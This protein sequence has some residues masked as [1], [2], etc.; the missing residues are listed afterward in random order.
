MS[1]N[2][3]QLYEEL[4]FIDKKEFIRFSDFNN[5][6]FNNISLRYQNAIKEMMPEAMFCLEDEPFILFF[7]LERNKNYEQELVK[8]YRQ[9]WNFDKAPVVVV[10]SP[11]DI[12][13]YNAF[14]F[15]KDTNRL[16]ILTNR[17]EDFQNFAYENLYTG[18]IFNNYEN[19]FKSKLRV[20][21]LLFKQ[22][23]DYR[24]ELINENINPSFANL[25]LSRIIFIKY[26]KDRRIK[27]DEKND[28]RII[29]GFKN[30][31]NLYNLFKYLKKEFNGD[32]FDITDNEELSISDKNMSTITSF[33]EDK[34]ISGQ[35]RLFIPFDFSIIPIELIS[36]IYEQFLNEQQYENKAYY[37]PLF[38]VDY[39]TNQ[40]IKKYLFNKSKKDSNCKVLDPACGSGIFLIET[41]R[42][43]IQKEESLC[44]GKKIKAESL[45]KLV[46][47]NIFGIDKDKDA[48]NIAI[49]SL[50]ITLLDYQEPKSILTFKFPHLKDTNFFVANFFDTKHIFNNKLNQFDFILSNPPYGEINDKYQIN[51]FKN[52]KIPINDKQIA[53]SFLVRVKDFC[54]KNTLVSML[55]LSKILYNVKAKKFRKYFLENF[56]LDEV[57]EMS[58]VRKLV[59]KNAIAPV[60]IITY[61]YNDNIK[62]N[63]QSKFVHYTLKPN[64]F[65]K[66]FN[67][68][69][70]EKYDIKTILQELVYKND[71]LWKTLLFGNILDFHFIKRIITSFKTIN[72]KKCEI[73][74]GKGIQF[75]GGDKQ[76]TKHIKG[77]P[78]LD[79]KN[80]QLKRFNIQL[81]KNNKFTDDY[82]HRS[83]YSIKEIFDAPT[84]LIKK[85]CNSN[86]QCVS[87]VLKENAVFTDS[88]GS[89]KFKD[90]NSD[91]LYSL[92]GVLNSDF[93][94]Y[95]I[96]NYISAV[97]VERN[98]MHFQECLEVPYVY[99]K[100]LATT[101]KDLHELFDNNKEIFSKKVYEIQNK[102]TLLLKTL[103]EHVAS[104]YHLSSTEKDLID[105]TLNI[106]IPLWKFGDNISLSTTPSALKNVNEE[107]LQDY[108]DIFIEEFEEH[109][110]HFNID[111]YYM[112]Y[113]T[114]I[115]F[116]ARENKASKP[117]IQIIKNLKFDNVIKSICNCTITDISDDIYIKKDVKGFNENSFYILK[118]N[119]YKN[120]HKAIARLDVNE[121][122]NAIWEAELEL[123]K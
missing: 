34:D 121:F 95:F 9:T 86:F 7:N 11:N 88:I 80:K 101:V 61:S 45:K 123:T 18:K 96:L 82:V 113:C 110:K 12:T 64:L 108:C 25:L 43:I 46:E 8:I 115:N 3:E 71:W 59:F 56:C 97:T 10:S 55:V 76:T 62:E 38:I 28:N 57:L 72:S 20:Q 1:S 31:E 41:L 74:K 84:L 47:N 117:Q 81:D 54:S 66:Y 118:T 16:D 87:A 27:I 30:K 60:A 14:D 22:I 58:S 44:S 5:D 99:D 120:W 4:N 106:S 6:S 85:G 36:S 51:W 29:E 104:L 19:K 67:V 35:E 75:G 100:N 63:L 102:E 37:T 26:L 122:S 49:F 92:C 42:K 111:I 15:D 114:L 79:T 83:R 73:I 93:F 21:D 70:I 77:L 109:Y 69:I 24:T 13:F 78:F 112:K 90:G 94:T 48:I 68:I 23:V 89:I 107:Q 50:Y 105:Y 39:I 32:L 91:K 33:F 103:N 52:N 119:E 40:T 53:Q 65:F 116:K 17:K 2:L 98:Q